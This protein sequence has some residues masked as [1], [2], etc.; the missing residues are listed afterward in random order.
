MKYYSILILQFFLLIFSFSCGDSG[1]KI[2]DAWIRE[3]PPGVKMAALYMKIEN[4]GSK[5]DKLLFLDSS[6]CRIA[7]IHNTAVNKDGI[8]K[9]ER[10]ES[11]EIPARNTVNFAPGDLH[12]MLIDLRADIKNGDEIDIDLRF[13]R[14]G[15]KTVKAV[16]RGFD[17]SEENT[18]NHQ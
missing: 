7:E 4:N 17:S 9:M 16:V 8:A 10:L 14:S 13:E 18:H 15:S 5:G 11:L 3:V 12:I 6:I 2:T 1:I